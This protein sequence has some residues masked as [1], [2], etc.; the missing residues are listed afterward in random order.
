M[1]TI[2]YPGSDLVPSVAPSTVATLFNHRMQLRSSC[3]V[4]KVGIRSKQFGTLEAGPSKMPSSHSE[5][6]NPSENMALTP[7]DPS[8]TKNIHLVPRIPNWPDVRQMR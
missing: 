3:I 1:H 7:L 5:L 2:D 4:M 6:Y 8:L